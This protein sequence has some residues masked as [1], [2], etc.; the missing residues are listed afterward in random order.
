[1]ARELSAELH[2]QVENYGIYMMITLFPSGLMCGQ[3][4]NEAMC[5]GAESTR[6]ITLVLS[7][8]LE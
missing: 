8:C 1:M 3:Y 5:L 6:I 4:A 7:A 2:S